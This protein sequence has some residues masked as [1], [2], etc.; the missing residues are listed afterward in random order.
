MFA[1]A[2]QRGVGAG[3]ARHHLWQFA[4]KT[5]VAAFRAYDPDQGHSGGVTLLT[6]RGNPS[7]LRANADIGGCGQKKA[8]S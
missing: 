8:P 1:G 5:A 4:G 2:E 7:I 3:A 6:P